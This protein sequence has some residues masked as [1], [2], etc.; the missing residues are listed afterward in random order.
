[1]KGKR[2]HEPRSL[3]VIAASPAEIAD[4]YGI[5]KPTLYIYLRRGELLSSKVGGRR[6]IYLAD[7]DAFLDARRERG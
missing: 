4:M 1:M 6:I 3:P 5:S 7:M 2:K